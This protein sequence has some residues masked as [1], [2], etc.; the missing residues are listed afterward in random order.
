MR[1]LGIETSCDETAAAIVENGT[2]SISSAVASSKDLLAK[3]G[4]VFPEKAAREQ[5]K[6]ILPVI[7]ESLDLSLSSSNPLAT[8][9]EKSLAIEKR[10]KTID[11]IAVTSG[12]GL[13]GSLLIGVETAKTLACV[14]NKPII[15][16]NHLLGHIYANWI[17]PKGERVQQ[18]PTLPALCLIVSGGHTLLVI[19]NDHGSFKKIGETRDDAAG[20]AF[21]KTARLLGL[22]YPGGPQI[23]KMARQGDKTKFRF[24]RPMINSHDYD[25]SFSG[26]KTAVWREVK[27]L[28]SQ[29]ATGNSQLVSDLAAG[30]Q[31]A[32]VEVLV[33]KTIHA[34]E[35]Y[36]V[37][38]II[39]GGGVAANKRLTEKFL[40]HNALFNIHIPPPSLCTDNATVIAGAAFFNYHPIPWKDIQADAGLPFP[41]NTKLYA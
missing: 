33:K 3:Y 25:F 27:K 26:L 24:P 18:T 13:I 14:F 36:D 34:A 31:E 17:T 4:G 23:A 7:E 28:D 1:I 6:C 40:I 29:L 5:L 32:I 39:V 41:E 22:P 35:E 9:K 10:M 12:P 38:S 19:M 11:A 20:E 37:K 30:I 8:S 21:D 2:R 15:P 16:V